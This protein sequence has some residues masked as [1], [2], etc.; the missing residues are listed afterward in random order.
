MPDRPVILVTGSSGL[1]GRNVIARFDD[2]YQ[3]VGFDRDGQ[4]QP[5]KKTECVC[6]DITDDHSVEHGLERTAYAYGKHLAGV[7]HLAAY[8]SFSNPESPLFEQVTV[9]GTRRLLSKLKEKQFC[10]D[11]FIFSSTMLVHAPTRPGMPINEQSPLQGKWAYPESKIRTE[12]VIEEFADDYPTAILRIAGVYTDQG[13]SIPIGQQISR[14]YHEKL[15]GK[16][17]PGDVSHGQSFVHLDDALDAIGQVLERGD[18][19]PRH[20]TMLIGEPEVYSYDVLQRAIAECLHDRGEQWETHRVPEALARIGSW[21]Q[22]HTPGMD[23]PFIQPWMVE[24]ADD[25]YEL[26]I[27]R[28]R[29]LLGWEPKHRLI[30]AIPSMCAA[31]SEHARCDPADFKRFT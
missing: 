8:A 3:V 30:E 25:H 24:L 17:Y 29:R 4:P 7:I 22:L 2:D 19:L 28:A 5:P 26:D 13:D 23:E 12:Q 10:V 31:I 11:R 21:V 1:L 18:D 20:C 15:T 9:Q 16:V 27:S 6:V 14:I